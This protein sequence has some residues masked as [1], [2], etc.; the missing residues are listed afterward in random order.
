MSEQITRLRANDFEEAIDL[1]NL[2]FSAHRPHDFERLLPKLYQPT[3]ESMGR[4]LAVKRDGRI[5]AIVGVYPIEL[6]IGNTPLTIAGIGGVSVHPRDRGRGYMKRLMEAALEQIHDESYE[7]SW[8]S[9]Q[10]QRYGYFG[11]EV[12]GTAWEFSVSDANVRH[13]YR[14][15]PELTFEK[16]TSSD[17]ERIAAVVRWHDDHAVHC[18]R[19]PEAFFDVAVSW[20]HELFV[21][22]DTEGRAVGYV[23]ADPS[24]GMVLEAR[25]ESEATTRALVPAW[26]RRHGRG[27]VSFECAPVP[28][29][30][31]D[32]LGRV[33]EGTGIRPV[34]NWRIFDWQKVMRA[35]LT[36]RREKT[37][38]QPG[39]IV[40]GI[41]E[42]GNLRIAVSSEGIVCE[43][44]DEVPAIE[45]SAPVAMRTIFGPLPPP[46]NAAASGSVLDSWCP[47][48]LFMPRQ[49]G[50]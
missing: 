23:I 16:V 4:H 20:H 21:A 14:S 26:V 32:E 15:V 19:R 42:Y 38:L 25:G 49:D 27:S 11:Y 47:L 18:T 41:E 12:C 40:V 5:R 33:A 3:D 1:L 8:L 43:R 9:G 6:N 45:M 48:P 7:I 35:L 46:A 39:E 44:T 30:L 13:S 2:V 36:L 50:V 24:S 34:G 31:V 22:F 17:D 37:G 28:S 29:P 10:R